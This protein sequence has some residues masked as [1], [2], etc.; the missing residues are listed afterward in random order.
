MY[1]G[2]NSD[3]GLTTAFREIL[4]NSVDEGLAGFGSHITLIF[5]QDGS[6]EVQD[7]GR[8]V[9]VDYN[10][11]G[12][13]GI[14]L[15]LGNTGAGG[16]FND[17]NYAVSGGLN[18]VGAAA[19][20][21]AST[22]FDATVYRD[23]K[24]HRLSFKEGKPGHFAQDNDPNSKFTPSNKLKVSKDTRTAAQKK[25]AP[26]GTTIRFWPDFSV[27]LPGSKILVEEIRSRVKSTAF[28]VPGLSFT[29]IDARESE[30][31]PDIET[32]DFDGGLEDMLP[33]L[34]NHDLY[35][36]PVHIKTEGG[37]SEMRNVLGAD[38]TTVRK[39]VERKVSID[40][41]FG[42][43]VQSDETVL[44]SYVNLI[45]TNNG[46]THESGLWRA[47][48]RVLIN[49]VK[50]TKGFLKAKE[51]PPI[52]EDVKD[53][54]IGIISISFPEP[55]FKGQEKSTLDTQQIVSVVSQEVGT[56]LQNWLGQKKNARMAKLIGDKIVEASRVRLAAKQQKE[57][58][59]KK[60]ALETATSMP[61]KLVE[62]EFVGDSRSELMLVEGD[63]ALGT[64]RKARDARFQALFP[65]RGKVLNVQKATTS[66][67]L[68]NAECAAMIQV[69]GAGSGKTF[70]LEERRYDKVIIQTDA[71]VDG[72]HI[73]TLLIT[74]FWKYM[75]DL[76]LAGKL[77][78]AMPPLFEA[79]INPGMK[80]EQ[81]LYALDQ[82]E[83]NA[84]TK[85]YQSKKVSISRN[86]GLGEMTAEGAFETL[87]NPEQRRL[88]QITAD[89]VEA[90][91]YYLDLAMG[92]AVP[93]RKEWISTSRH[94][95][96]DED[97]DM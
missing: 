10:A 42:Y 93:P 60:S 15:T 51:E 78:A 53:G 22:R 77:Y 50:N 17:S 91:E 27:F 13:S 19:A 79:K 88:K 39:E 35:T 3:D 68:G 52:L 97:L 20:N 62:C 40:V 90:A 28:L 59:K 55:T 44:K 95:V 12:I 4:D 58:A 9:P 2:G 14:E 1:L 66:A 48:S 41:A 36:K 76:V 34:S 70:E 85:K 21:A 92:S 29:F 57:L 61:P 69:M 80:D 67:M 75:K 56:E 45:R 63:S 86:K 71:D 72:A 32:Y 74:F 38:N 65:L 11:D 23:G 82:K 96:S 87:L 89:D 33:T 16:K 25:K 43:T 31:N 18:G 46:G 37:F 83:L 30:T 7:A 24:V 5:H 8:G 73:K 49:Y 81:T 94:K 84:I 54:F 26:T 47:L 6:A 64:M